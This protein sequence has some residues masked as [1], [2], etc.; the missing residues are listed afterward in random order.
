MKPIYTKKLNVCYINKSKCNW[1]WNN[2]LFNCIV[3]LT[4]LINRDRSHSSH[5]LL[6][7]VIQ[8]TRISIED[9]M[10]NISSIYTYITDSK[11]H[12]RLSPI[13]YSC[14]CTQWGQNQTNLTLKAINIDI[15][16]FD[17][18]NG[19][20]CLESCPFVNLL[21]F[22]QC[23]HVVLLKFIYYGHCVTRFFINFILR[24]I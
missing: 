14:T 13:E 16:C 19:C 10:L 22:C 1:K 8:C 17:L 21:H 3:I 15:I 9:A 18:T 24:Y 4:A 5:R 23:W 7:R 6:S 11:G 20:I 12:V 2:L